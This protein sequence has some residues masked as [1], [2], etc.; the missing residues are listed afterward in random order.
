[1]NNGFFNGNN[2][3]QIKE[4]TIL[5]W[6]TNIRKPFEVEIDNTI[7]EYITKNNLAKY[8]VCEI[9]DDI[10]INLYRHSLLLVNNIDENDGR[11][12]LMNKLILLGLKEYDAKLI[13]IE[14]GASQIC[15]NRKYLQDFEFNEYIIESV[16]SALC[17]FYMGE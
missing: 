5:F 16:L 6:G 14:A 12:L 11:F 10:D 7:E 2:F 17:D 3:Y 8:E 13:A 4:K 9:N 15:V 1:M